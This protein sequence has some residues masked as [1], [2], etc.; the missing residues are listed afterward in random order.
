ML[1]YREAYEDTTDLLAK[2]A[3]KDIFSPGNKPLTPH[4]DLTTTPTTPGHAREE[5]LRGAILARL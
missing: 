4:I 1:I 2:R 5:G 3:W